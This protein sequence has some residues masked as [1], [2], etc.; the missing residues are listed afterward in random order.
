[1]EEVGV[2]M[3]PEE[4]LEKCG[5]SFLE[6]GTQPKVLH[7][8]L[9]DLRELAADFDPVT[10]VAVREAAIPRLR[11][12]GF[13]AP[14]KLVDAAQPFTN[15]GTADDTLQGQSIILRV[16][17]PWEHPVDGA[18]LLDEICALI[19]Q[20]VILPEWAAEAIA[21]W[22]IHTYLIDKF[23]ITPRL[24]FSSPEKRCGKTTALELL[25]YVV[26]KPIPT[27]NIT[28]S[29]LFRTI[30][31]Y[32]PTLLVDEGDTFLRSE[33]LRGVLNSGHTRALGFAVRTAGDDY[34]PRIFRVF[35]PVVIAL[36]GKLADTLEDRSIVVSMK[37][38]RP[39]E[40]VSRFRA[41]KVL[42][43]LEPIG[44]K[45]ARWALDHSEINRE[46]PPVPGGLNDRQADC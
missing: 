16:P 29:A 46:D 20:Y 40:A 28:A 32:S 27:S 8:M 4:I 21:L 23:N 36:I 37:R 1:M 7:Q 39:D 2:S 19:R 13:Q 6:K 5:F 3:S 34:E 12:A 18:A 41:E 31:K 45:A 9:N 24:T 44:R 11:E 35:S 10:W 15:G 14:A 42:A 30:E 17:E 43:E 25:G 26:C 38:K 33:E 22:V